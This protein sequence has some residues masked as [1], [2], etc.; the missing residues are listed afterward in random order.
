MADMIETNGLKVA[1]V[2]FDFIE[3]DVLPGTGIASGAFWSGFAK[4]AGDL[5]PKNRA[6][7]ARRDD[8]Q[9]Q[10]DQWHIARRGKVFD[11][12]EYENFLRGIGYL[13]QEGADFSV[14][15]PE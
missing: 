4:L 6:L 9:H 13:E 2:L 10:I 15:T 14:T 11:R 8:L 5:A 3:K 1:R 12:S 7:L